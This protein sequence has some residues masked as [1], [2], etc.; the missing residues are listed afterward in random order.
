MRE[1][2]P[3]ALHDV[4]FSYRHSSPVLEGV[5]LEVGVGE[6]VA[7][8]GPSGTG[9]SSLLDICAGLLSADSG[10][11]R[12]VGHDF[13]AMTLTGRAAVRRRE[14]GMVFQ[15]PELLP[16]LSVV[17][18][19][20]LVLIFDGASRRKALERATEALAAVRIAH[21]AGR[22]VHEISGGEA[23]RVALARSLAQPDMRLVVADE[24]TASLDQGNAQHVI[25]LLVDNVRARGAGALVATHDP[26]VAGRCDRV[27]HLGEPAA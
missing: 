5:V 10:R 24:P 22:R 12:V 11:V 16:E 6:A 20:A 26:T 4:T 23:Q 15:A 18:N 25:D 7:V 17:E 19:V 9:K 13:T 27:V 14:L 2:S 3:L 21:L 1:T 8:M